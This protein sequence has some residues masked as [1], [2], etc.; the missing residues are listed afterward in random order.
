MA[1]STTIKK[2]PEKILMSN[3]GKELLKNLYLVRSYSGFEEPLRNRIIYFLS[4]W[5][6]PFINYNGN[7][8]GFNHPKAPLFS[9]HMDMVN[10]ESYKLKGTEIEVENPVFT[11]D[12]KACLR[13]YRGPQK[14]GI[15]TSLGADDKNGIWVILMLLKEGKQINFAFCH[16]EEVGGIGSS[17]IVKDKDLSSFIEECPFGIVIDRRNAHDIIGFENKYCLTLDDKLEQFSKERGYKFETA[18]GSISDADKFSNLIECVNLSC[19]YYEP[20]TSK[21]YTNLNELW[22]TLN[23]CRDIVDH[24]EFKPVSTKRIKAFKG[25]GTTTTTYPRSTYSGYS[26]YYKR[27]NNAGYNAY[28]DVDDEDDW[29]VYS[30]RSNSN[31]NTSSKSNVIITSSSSQKKNEKKKTQIAGKD[32]SDKSTDTTSTNTSFTRLFKAYKE[33]LEDLGAVYSTEIDAY[34]V[35]L[36][37]EHTLPEGTAAEDVLAYFVCDKCSSTLMLLQDSLDPLLMDYHSSGE[38]FNVK[39]ICMHCFDSQ[40]I[41][42]DIK[43]YL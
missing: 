15:R 17:Q 36:Y 25:V 13:L 19:G 23:F 27:N 28:Y 12:D 1:N 41:T 37:T 42:K 32:C 39:G 34:L 43:Y 29:S 22:N 24:F 11:I 20:H 2:E 40:D 38:M 33:D 35:P 21:E 4:K 9:A 8:L 5:N 16:S 18:R 30:S 3:Y 7:I 31:N 6:I 14:D 26:G 10:T